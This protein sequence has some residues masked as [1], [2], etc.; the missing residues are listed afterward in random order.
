M[1]KMKLIKNISVVIL[2]CIF[3]SSCNSGNNFNNS[4]TSETTPT[5]SSKTE[6]VT[7]SV[8]KVQED[9]DITT[10]KLVF[11]TVFQRFEGFG[12]GYTWYS[13]RM[14]MPAIKDEIADLLFKDAKLTI[15]RFKNEYKYVSDTVKDDCRETQIYNLAAERTAEYNEKPI[16]L[17]SCWS[18][19]SYLKG[20]GEIGGEGT[21]KKNDDGSYM[22]KEYAEWWAESIEAYQNAGIPIDYISIQNECDLA[23]SYDGMSF[24]A[25]ENGELA[26]Y[27]KAHLSVY[28]EI[29]NKFGSSAPLMLAPETMSFVNLTLKMY[30]SD[31]LNAK[32]ESVAGVAFHLYVGGEGT[33][34]G[35]GTSTAEPKS[36]N[37]NL[38]ANNTDFGTD[39][40][41]WQTE[42]YI[43]SP[44]DTAMIIMNSLVYGNVSSYIHWTGIWGGEN[45]RHDLI[46]VDGNGDY[47]VSSVYWV[48]RH[49]SEFI[50]PGY[51]RIQVS[52]PFKAGIGVCAFINE[53]KDTLAIVLVNPG[54]ESLEAEIP[55]DGFNISG[56]EIYQSIFDDGTYDKGEYYNYLGELV[57]NKV[58]LPAGSITTI[59]LIGSLN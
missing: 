9:N 54:E 26:A 36:F 47:Y 7:E 35:D 10:I 34:K 17:M 31:I 48:M 46:A 2:M 56:S 4:D 25:F 24:A 12:A 45:V 3:L 6:A 30:L 33:D 41:L 44:L 52:Y 11:D 37:I 39:Y 57:N 38:I 40:Q 8:T 43:G 19:P 20:N 50:R 21:L 14:L 27:S 53:D 49:Y 15:L 22:Y 23:P 28:D 59:S 5:I 55:T 42:Y 16:V 29:Q 13:E 18:P 1:E 32:P 51:T 58:T